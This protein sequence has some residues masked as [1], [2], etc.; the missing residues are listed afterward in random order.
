MSD[1]S[2]MQVD[3]AAKNNRQNTPKQSGVKQSTVKLQ[4]KNTPTNTRQNQQPATPKNNH[5]N[6]PKQPQHQNLPKQPQH[7]PTNTP[8]KSTKR[9]KQS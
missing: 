9:N 7:Q 6:T 1:E 4:D 2:L 5:Q 8:H 3:T